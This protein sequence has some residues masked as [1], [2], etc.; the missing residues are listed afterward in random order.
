[1]EARDENIKELEKKIAKPTRQ[2]EAEGKG[3]GSFA[4][5]SSDKGRNIQDDMKSLEEVP[6]AY[7]FE[8]HPVGV[9]LSDV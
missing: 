4:T 6:S 5:L 7:S 9:A 3:V 1:M 2:N 8:G